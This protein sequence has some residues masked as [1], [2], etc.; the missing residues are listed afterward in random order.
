M[1]KQ[2]VTSPQANPSERPLRYNRN[3]LLLWSGQI[4]SDLGTRVTTVAFPLLVITMTNS[5]GKAGIAG[6][7]ATLPYA[8]FYLPAGAMLDQYDRRRIML[9]CEIGRFLALGSI[10]FAAWLGYLTFPHVLVVAFVG[11]TFFVF[12]SVA[13]KSIV[14]SLV[15]QTQLTDALARQEARSRAAVL[16]GPPLG[17]VLYG[18]SHTIPFLFD[19]VSYV[20]SLV[21]TYFIRADLKAK[22]QQPAGSLLKEVRDG[23]R[24]LVREPFIRIS[25]VLVGLINIVFQALMLTLIVLT[26]QLGASSA[27]TGVVLGCYGLGGLAGALAA[28][29]LQH[30]VSPKSVA[31]GATWIWAILLLPLSVV[32]SLPG[33]CALVAMISFFGP[34]WNVVIV[35]YQYRVI[36]DHLLSRIKSVVLLVSWGTIPF[37]SLIAGYFLGKTSPEATVLVLV[38]LMTVIATIATFSPGIRRV[39]K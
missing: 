18:I 37:G 20:V 39:A 22:R 35:G 6:F 19:A 5:P 36:P 38:A 25:V 24:W 30:H 27:M 11:G 26:R 28:P 34:L 21:T 10:P 15:P 17:G 31:I 29:R 4:V 16:A 12:F 7:C 32:S 23:V 14:P 8:L 13:E 3:F 33:M 2:P 9:V 1:K